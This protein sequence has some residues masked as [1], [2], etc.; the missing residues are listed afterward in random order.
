[1]CS[2]ALTLCSGLDGA[3]GS[4][5][6]PALVPFAWDLF[7]GDLTHEDGVLV[8]LDVQIFQILQD[9]Q[10]ALCEG[11]EVKGQRDQGRMSLFGVFQESPF[12][13]RPEGESNVNPSLVIRRM[14]IHMKL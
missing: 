11:R 4:N 8:F 7:H 9:L 10:L 14:V 5:L 6:V 3:G 13:C 1:M 12:G 2:V